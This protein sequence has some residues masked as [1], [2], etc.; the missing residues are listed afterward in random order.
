[1]VIQERKEKAGLTNSLTDVYP[2]RQCT[3]PGQHSYDSCHSQTGMFLRDFGGEG[4]GKR[5]Y[6]IANSEFIVLPTVEATAC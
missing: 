5:G 2:S 3:R 1:M 6:I 4:M